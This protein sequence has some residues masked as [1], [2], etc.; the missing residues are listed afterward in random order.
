MKELSENIA[1]NIDFN[2]YYHYSV[3]IKQKF[4]ASKEISKCFITFIKK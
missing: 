2:N 1:F 4:S 3:I